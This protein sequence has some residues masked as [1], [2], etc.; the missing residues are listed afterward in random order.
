[1]NPMSYKEITLS[2]YESWLGNQGC[3]TNESGDYFIYSSERNIKQSGYSMPIDIYVWLQSDKIVISYGDAAKAKIDELKSK[4]INGQDVS[5]ITSL[6]FNIYHCDIRH[7]IKYIF[8][9]LPDRP[10][11]NGARTLKID[12]YCDFEK[13]FYFCNPDTEN[14]D[15]LREYFYNMVQLGYCVGVYEN[16]I[17]VSCT[18]APS[19]PYM[20][21]KVQ[22]IGISTLLGYRGKGYATIACIKAEENILSSGKVPLWSTTI[23]NIASQR[24]AERIGF[25]KIA[26][27]F[28]L[29]I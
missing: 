19:M 23:D 9:S 26:D 25:K 5:Y 4:L 24:L 14:I 12:D 17:L 22:E 27:V 21:D 3:I 1:M 7:D 2:Y 6:L 20:S 18:D 10:V 11:K 13:F 28:T 15:W 16:G 8:E 29:E